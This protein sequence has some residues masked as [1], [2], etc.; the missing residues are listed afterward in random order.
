MINSDNLEHF[1]IHLYFQCS[2]FMSRISHIHV[3]ML[4]TLGG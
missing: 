3:M 1:Y 4:I 2:I